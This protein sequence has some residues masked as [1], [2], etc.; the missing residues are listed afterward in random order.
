TRLD[1]THRDRPID[2]RPEAAGGDF[3]D[4]R[5]VQRDLGT[6]ARGRAP[7]RLDADAQARRPLRD[8]ALDAL[9]AGKAA[10][11]APALLDRPGERGLDR[12][13]ARV[14]VVP[15]EAKPGFQPQ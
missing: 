6:L 15:V 8:F 12:R 14:D 11:R 9:R 1:I 4:R 13:R 2:A 5:I 3:A 10:F 7:F